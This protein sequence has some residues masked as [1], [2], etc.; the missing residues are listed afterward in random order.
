MDIYRLV[1]DSDKEVP[2]TSFHGYADVLDVA[3]AHLTAYQ[4]DAA[5]NQRFF[6]TTGSYSYQMISDILRERLSLFKIVCVY[7][8]NTQ[9]LF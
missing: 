4:D 2:Q 8:T 6:I 1:I 9:R 3:Q 7:Y 5:A